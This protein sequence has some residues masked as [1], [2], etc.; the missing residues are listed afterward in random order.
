MSGAILYKLSDQPV[1]GL[2]VKMDAPKMDA[3]ALSCGVII[4]TQ[5]EDHSGDIVVTDGLSL[6]HH[7]DNPVV[8]YDHARPGTFALPIGKA[9]S[10]DGLYQVRKEKGRILSNTFFSKRLPEGEQFYRLVEDGVLLG[11]SIGFVPKRHR[12]MPD[13]H[14]GQKQ[15]GMIFDESELVEYSHTPTP[16]NPECLAFGLGRPYL[17]SAVLRKSLERFA[18]PQPIS[19]SVPEGLPVEKSMTVDEFRKSKGWKPWKDRARGA[20]VVKVRVVKEG[21]YMPMN[22]EEDR[23]KALSAATDPVSS[24]ADTNPDTVEDKAD[25]DVTG[26]RYADGPPGARCLSDTYDKLCDMAMHCA[27]SVAEQE[28]PDVSAHMEDLAG[29]TDQKMQ[30]TADLFSS[31]YPDLDSL[32]SGTAEADDSRDDVDA[33][34][35]EGK[36]VKTTKKYARLLNHPSMASLVNRIRKRRS[37]D[38]AE[39]NRRLSK[40]A[41]GGCLRVAKFL[42]SIAAGATPSRAEVAD[43]ALVL[44]RLAADPTADPA[45]LQELR[46][47]LAKLERRTSNTAKQLNRSISQGY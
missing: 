1:Y 16:D 26:H 32:D 41:A 30:D 21:D 46:E 20:Q 9:I 33:G 35:E 11:A 24:E 27:D 22:D 37:H 8:L 39:R 31:T 23:D 19:V 42:D 40:S 38:K 12:F 15:G 10:P 28:H 4:S 44:K 13:R 34:D 47:R 17:K 45:E 36:P 25:D 14:I 18:P 43:H 2:S 5:A 7:E 29:H 6:V 3:N